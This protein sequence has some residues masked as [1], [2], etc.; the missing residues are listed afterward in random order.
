[1]PA[2]KESLVDAS[3]GKSVRW[4]EGRGWIEESE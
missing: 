3:A 2:E 4:I 1:L